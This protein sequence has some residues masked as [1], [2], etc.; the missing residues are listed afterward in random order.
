MA[1]TSW[2][3]LSTMNRMFHWITMYMHT[4]ME[5]VPVRRAGL[6]TSAKSLSSVHPGKCS[7]G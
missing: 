6:G 7:R 1:A 2:T 4:H 3:C 5:T